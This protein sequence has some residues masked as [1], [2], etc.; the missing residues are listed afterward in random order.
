MAPTTS[1]DGCCRAS[2][3]CAATRALPVCTAAATRSQLQMDDGAQEGFDHVVLATQANQARRLLQ[4]ASSRRAQ[5]LDGFR[6]QPVQVLMH[7]D[8]RFMPAHGATGRR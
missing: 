5:V 4:D 1:N 8:A 2:P 7:H 3:T 6:Y